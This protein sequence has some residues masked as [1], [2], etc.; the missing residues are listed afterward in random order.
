M[1]PV[2]KGTLQ[3]NLK[4]IG[5]RILLVW[6]IV[7]RNAG[8]FSLSGSLH[9]AWLSTT[10]IADRSVCHN[11]ERQSHLKAVEARR[12]KPRP[13][14]ASK[15]PVTVAAEFTTGFSSITDRVFSLKLLWHSQQA[16]F[17]GRNE[18]M[19]RSRPYRVQIG[20]RVDYSKQ[21]LQLQDTNKL[22]PSVQ[23]A[24]AAVRRNAP[25]SVSS[26]CWI[27]RRFTVTVHHKNRSQSL[28][29]ESVEFFL[30]LIE[31]P[32]ILFELLLDTYSNSVK[33]AFDVKSGAILIYSPPTV[34][35]AVSA[36]YGS[37]GTSPGPQTISYRT[38]T[39]RRDLNPTFDAKWIV[40]GIPDSGFTLNLKLMDEDPGNHDDQLG[41][42]IIRFPDQEREA[43]RE[44][45]DSGEVMYKIRKRTGSVRSKIVTF[46]AKALTRGRYDHRCR[47]WVSAKVI[48]SVKVDRDDCRL[49]TVGPRTFLGSTKAP[50][51]EQDKA[52]P[53]LKAST[54]VAN[55][56]Q[57]SG[58]IPPSLRHRYVGFAPFVKAMFKKEGIEGILLHRAL[59]HQHGSI[60]KWDKNVVWG[61]IEGD[62]GDETNG[63]AD[64]N[65]NSEANG[66]TP[67]NAEGNGKDVEITE[68]EE[69]KKKK[70]TSESVALARQFLRMTSHGT[71]GRLFTYETGA[72]FAIGL[73]SKHTMHSDVS[74]E[75]AYSG[76]FFVRPIRHHHGHHDD[77]QSH[78]EGSTPEHEEDDEYISENPAD[79]ELVIDN[80]SGTYRPRKDLLPV[81]Q[82]FLSSPSNLCAL[83]KITAMD[84]FDERLKKWKEERANI[85]AGKRKAENVGR[86][87]QASLSSSSSSARSS[88]V[89]L[90]SEAR[91]EL[92]DAG[93][94]SMKGADVQAV[95]EEDANR[96][97]ENQDKDREAKEEEKQGGPNQ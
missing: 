67:E 89:S 57:L 74:L 80:D 32:R 33:E 21:G 1:C 19:T 62:S 64:G 63:G 88:S 76:E 92:K 23:A 20:P 29:Q 75:I 83:G 59:H 69:T 5:K 85:K 28:A 90:E 93:T 41:K 86:V 4:V 46:L 50:N 34:Q 10:W 35:L 11:P 14:I 58:P 61:V 55:R 39:V 15:E 48:G 26:F 65:A 49:Y 81:L 71:H 9:G 60:Y 72:E 42:A 12:H 96:A 38:H 7:E 52:K 40:A 6:V 79:Y 66:Q 2:K 56:I 18:S 47:V 25:E 73:L 94:T 97:R 22:A 13:L 70:P 77:S 54:F 36:D 8:P 43:F 30:V 82:S 45:W 17:G 27:R 84:G 87:A 95:L 3:A 24:R 16:V 78:T 91:R 68:R 51:R 53:S 44:G 31:G 37:S